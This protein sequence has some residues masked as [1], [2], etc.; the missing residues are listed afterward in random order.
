[1]TKIKQRNELSIFEDFRIKQKINVVKHKVPEEK[2]LKKLNVL[3]RTFD[4][5]VY[6]FHDK[7]VIFSK[8]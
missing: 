1:M 8:F 3:Y 6:Y 4:G 7:V 5:I 2:D